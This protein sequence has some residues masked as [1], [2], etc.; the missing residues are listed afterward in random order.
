MKKMSLSLFAVAALA[1]CTSA[2][3][4]PTVTIGSTIS[5]PDI[6]LNFDGITV[7][8]D[9][10]TY[11]ENGINVTV[12]SVAYVGFHAFTGYD[13]R[14]DGFHYG[15]GGNNGYVTIKG[16]KD[17]VFSG[18]GFLVGNGYGY[19]YNFVT[20]ATYLNGTLSGEGRVETPN[21]LISFVDAEGFDE[22]RVSADSFRY[23][24]FG[25]FQAIAIDDLKID[26]K[27]AVSDVPEPGSLALL[28]LGVIGLTS[29]RR[30]KSH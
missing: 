30:Q 24:P 26:I 6:S 18:I 13:T 21:G 1:T 14:S 27:D 19:N 3:A 20:Y 11:Q 29:I 16:A 12:G 25:E 7:N 23:S 15:S 4:V 2:L 5:N 10:S 28:G 17:E 9:L 8:Q 22:L